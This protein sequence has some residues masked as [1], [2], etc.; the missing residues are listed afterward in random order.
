[1]KGKFAPV[2]LAVIAL[3]AAV[4]ACGGSV[5]TANIS[6][7]WMSTDKEGNSKTATFSPDQIFYAQVEL[8]NAPD[9]TKV[10]ASWTA[11]SVEG[12]EPN[13]AIDSAEITS[14]DGLVHFNLENNGSWP[15]GQYKVDL[16]LNDA[17]AKT[18]TF[19]VR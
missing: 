15:V 5:S 7:A 10:K 1:V 8:K 3:A 4:V 17:L 2:L 12:T 13:K 11:V 9:D 19:E 14:G 6:N 18:L 16:Y